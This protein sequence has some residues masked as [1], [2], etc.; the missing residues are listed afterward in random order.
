M[1]AGGVAVYDLEA[2]ASAHRRRVGLS[3]GLRALLRTAPAE[4]R[5]TRQL[6]FVLRGTPGERDAVVSVRAVRAAFRTWFEAGGWRRRARIGVDVGAGAWRRNA[7]DRAVRELRRFA[8]DAGRQRRADQA[9]L[10][11][12]SFA[13]F[14]QVHVLEGRRAEKCSSCLIQSVN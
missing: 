6:F 3:R 5:R 14:R 11:R 10:L 13:A 7:L 1:S 4:L 9:G 2:V 8:A 12:R